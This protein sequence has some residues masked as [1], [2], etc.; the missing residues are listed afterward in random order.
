M[1]K[2]EKRERRM[3]YNIVLTLDSRSFICELILIVILIVSS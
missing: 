2:R 3:N 1:E